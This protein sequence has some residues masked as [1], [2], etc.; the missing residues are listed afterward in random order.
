MDLTQLLG[1]FMQANYVNGVGQATNSSSADVAN[2]LGAALPSMLQGAQAQSANSDTAAG[3]LQAISDH[4]SSDISDLGAFGGGADL[5]DGDKIIGHL[6]GKQKNE[7]ITQVANNA[8]VSPKVAAS[9]MAAAAPL[10]LSMLGKEANVQAAASNSAASTDMVSGLMAG[11]LGSGDMTAIL[12]S[13]VGGQ[14]QAKKP[15][16]ADLL[17]SL[18]KML[19]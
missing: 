18:L 19:K 2:I 6:F 9:V 8:N 5:A 3:F 15:G 12:G 4:S 14:S 13:L 17:G 1:T 10:L 7:V 11:L 16:A